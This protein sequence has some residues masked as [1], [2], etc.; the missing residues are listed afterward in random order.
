MTKSTLRASTDTFIERLQ[1]VTDDEKTDILQGL[2]TGNLSGQPDWVRG[3]KEDLEARGM[4]PAGALLSIQRHIQN[5]LDL[6][7]DRK[8]VQTHSEA[9]VPGRHGGDGPSQTPTLGGDSEA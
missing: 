2:Q 1:S 9:Q 3:F 5:A 7:M 6:G 8:S 4:K